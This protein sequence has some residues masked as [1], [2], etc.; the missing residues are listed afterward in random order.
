MNRRLDLARPWS[1][2][3][4]F[5]AAVA[6]WLAGTTIDRRTELTVE[7]LGDHL[8]FAVAGTELVVRDTLGEVS[9]VTLWATDSIDPPRIDEWTVRHGDETE[10]LG[11]ASVPAR[12]FGDP[13][14]VGDWWVDSR[15][16]PEV[17]ADHR[18]SIVGDFTI[19]LEVRGRVVNELTI[20]VQGE[21]TTHFSFRRG[22]KD[23]YLAIR[24]DDATLVDATTI[25]PTPAADVGALAAQLLRGGAAAALMIGF[26]CLTGWAGRR[27]VPTATTR[28]GAE[29][30]TP[31]RRLSLPI[32][33]LLA[34]I[35]I[36]VSIWGAVDVLGG[37][38][39]Q[40]DEV[41]YLLQARWLLDGD[42][43]PESTAI[44]QHLRVPFTYLAGDRW[45]GH[46]P[47][48]WPALLA[49]GVATGLPELVNPLLSGVLVVLVFVLGR[50]IDDELT[51]LAAALIA[52][53]SPLIRLLGSS[54]FPHVACAVLVGVAFW[55]VLR[56]DHRRSGWR[57]GAGIGLALGACL[58]VRPLTALV[59]AV[60][61]GTWMI[62]RA[63][64]DDG[65]ARLKTT[66]A[67]A[68]VAGLAAS[69]PTFA[70]NL[71]TTGRV[72]KLPYSL[73]QGAMYAP[74]LVPFGIRN[75][76]ALAVSA[77]A[78]LFGW[79]WP[80]IIGGLALALP[81]GI[82]IMPVILH[83]SRPEDRLL[84]A[85]VAVFAV[86]LLPTRANGLHGYGA[87]YLVD[88]APCLVLLA[89]RGF[90]ELGRWASPSP[91]ASRAAAG[92]FVA[93][94]LGSLA[95]LPFRLALYRGYYD[96]DGGLERQLAAAGIDRAV[97]L[98][99]EGDW[100]PWGEAARLITGPRRHA[101][102]V[103]VDLGDNSV[104]ES[105]FPDRP[106]LRW[107]DGH[108]HRDDGGFH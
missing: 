42:V 95:V 7:R 44:Q 17:I 73:A 89:A 36:A 106:M 4:W 47:V 60:V 100:R 43:A 103:G 13:A 72:L 101:F 14:P 20:T 80:V 84:L 31:I 56:S 65:G 49:T 64:A 71:A 63:G 52:T 9:G 58:A 5:G 70:H 29:S 11:S 74:E 10:E 57:T 90:R 40:I 93:L 19:A 61:L 41:V 94:C 99:D 45:V 33:A 98:V 97:I 79:G 35:A 86:A 8:R 102:A 62:L 83:R 18:A 67:A 25:D 39:H 28:A 59:V 78:G 1:V 108:L 38:P 30:P 81:I 24:L 107:E 23:N 88:I 53:G 6:L 2:G 26:I 68:A 48:G 37:L 82:I 96:V 91:V 69:L 77:S 55:L 22:L 75:L 66:L 54:F 87:R 32:A 21:P 34:V 85:V 12:S 76:D 105:A 3:V 15:H 50:A 27:L 51:G 92:I 16:R 104:I 46:Y